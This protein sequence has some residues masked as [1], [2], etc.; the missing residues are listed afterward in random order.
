MSLTT[1]ATD[2]CFLSRPGPSYLYNII[3]FVVYVCMFVCYFVYYGCRNVTET[4]KEVFQGRG[5]DL[6]E[7]VQNKNLG[8]R[9]F[10]AHL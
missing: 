7:K 1:S 9:V 8:L 5:A 6:V 10:W 4:K 3:A 2:D